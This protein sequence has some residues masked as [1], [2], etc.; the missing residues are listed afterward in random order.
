MTSVHD[1]LMATAFV[2][3]LVVGYLVLY[4]LWQWK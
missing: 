4:K 3:W 1:I 2:A